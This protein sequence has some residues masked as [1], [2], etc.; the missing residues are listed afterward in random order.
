[1]LNL[2]C[3]NKMLLIESEGDFVYTSQDT[4]QPRIK[5]FTP[6]VNKKKKLLRKILYNT[7]KKIQTWVFE[8]TEHILLL[9]TI[10]ILSMAQQPLVGQGFLVIETS[11]SH[12]D[13][14]HS[15]GLI[16]TRDQPVAE[17]TTHYTHK[18]QTSMPQRDSNPQSQQASG[19]RSTA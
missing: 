2:T 7:C 13:A 19:P 5:H 10:I 15:V 6:H 18:R 4:T 11:R 14:P 8:H 16:W 3:A 1:M 17:T 12:S 9:I